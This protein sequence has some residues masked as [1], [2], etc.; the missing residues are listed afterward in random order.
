MAMSGSGAFEIARESVTAEQAAMR[1][2][3]EVNGSH[4][5]KCPFHGGEHFSLS[6]RNGG[7]NCFACG[8]HGDSIGFA[9]R[10]FG[11][12]RPMDALRR[13]DEDFGLGLGLKDGGR[14]RADPAALAAV[15]KKTA[16]RELLRLAGDA[17]WEYAL[18]LEWAREA[19][20]PKTPDA[21]ATDVWVF[22][23]K[24]AEYAQHT[25]Y[26]FK[27]MTDAGKLEWIIQNREAVGKYERFNKIAKR[28]GK[29]GDRRIA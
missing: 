20:A 9:Q 13:L 15:R 3:I 11:Y 29:D 10:L 12:A 7:F 28:F 17:L 8:E 1:Y 6:F 27:C 26:W 22:A 2:G 21:P 4:R 19:L 23:L 5:G 24:N 14:P 16:E 18:N 25:L